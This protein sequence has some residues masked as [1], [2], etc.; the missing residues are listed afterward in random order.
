MRKCFR[1]VIFSFTLAV[2]IF[3]FGCSKD[4]KLYKGMEDIFREK[5]LEMAK[6]KANYKPGAAEDVRVPE[7]SAADYEKLGDA[8]LEEGRIGL[9]FV[10]YNKAAALMPGDPEINYK[11]GRLLLKKGAVDEARAIFEE[12]IK[13]G[14]KPALGHEGLGRAFFRKGDLARAEENF[15]AAL[16]S[17]AAGWEIRNFL[18]MVCDRKGQFADA[19]RHYEAAIAENPGQHVLFNNLGISLYR[20][21]DYGRAAEMFEK[22]LDLNPQTKIYNNLALTLARLG[23]YAE[24]LQ[25]FTSVSNEWSALNNLGLIYLMEGKYRQAEDA[26][27]RAAEKSPVYF[28]KAVENLKKA[29]TRVGPYRSPKV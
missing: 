12:I 16:K 3:S 26:F 18:G 29:R 8:Y 20:S 22:A 13:E 6:L 11:I 2:V 21:G 14:K 15:E 7:G 19:A 4:Q 23:R 27:Q 17:G 24:A 5:K 1:P 25:V 10:N 28:E 9:A